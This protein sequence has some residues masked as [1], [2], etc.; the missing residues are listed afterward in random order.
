MLL[1]MV[2]MLHMHAT[3]TGPSMSA[4]KGLVQQLSGLLQTLGVRHSK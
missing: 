3:R 1:G 2:H 4:L